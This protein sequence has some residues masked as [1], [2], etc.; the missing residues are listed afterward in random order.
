MSQDSAETPTGRGPTTTI[1]AGRDW[2]RTLQLAL[3]T[4][5]LLDGVLQLQPFFFT[6]G[7]HGFSGMLS[8]TAAGNPG[9]IAHTITWNASVVGHHPSLADGAFAL[10]QLLLGAGIAWRPT[11]KPALAASVVWSLAVWWFGE[12]LGTVLAGQ[13]SPIS[14]GP[15]AVLFYGVLGIVLWPAE[16][17]GDHPPFVAARSLGVSGARALWTAVWVGM[18][19]LMLVS[20]RQSE[21]T[22][23]IILSVN[24]GEPGWLA[25]IDRHAAGVVAGQGLVVAVVFAAVFVL[26]AVAVWLPVPLG[27]AVLTVTVVASAAIWVVGQNFGMILPGGATDPNSGPLLILLALSYWPLQPLPVAGI[28]PARSGRAERAEPKPALSAGG[29]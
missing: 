29:A 2:R 26:T 16:R 7:S 22:R 1:V 19:A 28:A 8:G 24:A 13:G 23:D 12:G 21:G 5:W 11:L 14:G 27:R 18:A 4:V 25:A 6:S 9:W 15:G 3:A 17:A 10:I 20:G